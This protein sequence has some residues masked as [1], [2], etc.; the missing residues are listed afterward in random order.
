MATTTNKVTRVDAIETAAAFIRAHE[1]AWDAFGCEYAISDIIANLEGQ[2]SK[3]R[4]SAAKKR[5]TPT[6]EQLINQNLASTVADV[7]PT[8]KWVSSKWVANNVQGVMSTQKAVALM[9]IL[10]ANGYAK[11][12]LLKGRPV[13]AVVD[14]EGEPTDDNSLTC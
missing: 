10:T 5:S 11:R 3:M 4:T 2:A 12:A 8:D 1:D 9:R 6:K 13:Y 7:M 14:L